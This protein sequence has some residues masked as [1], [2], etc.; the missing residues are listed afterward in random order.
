MAATKRQS[1]RPKVAVF[2]DV[3]NLSEADMEWII[4]AAGRLGKTAMAHGY[5][6]FSNYR[7]TGAAAERLFVLGIRLIHCPSWRNGGTELKNAADETMMLDI[8]RTLVDRPDI[9]RYVICTGDGHFVPVVRQVRTS[10]KEV[11]VITPPDGAS[12]LLTAAATR[13][14]TAPVFGIPQSADDN[15]AVFGNGT[16]AGRVIDSTPKKSGILQLGSSRAG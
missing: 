12:F 13:Y 7:G 9:S 4:R 11:I 3:A 16:G 15:R 6:S 8:Q 1:D 5:G 10:G 2:I 14:L